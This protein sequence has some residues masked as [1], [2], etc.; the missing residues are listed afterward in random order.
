LDL[1]PELTAN[2]L[3]FAIVAALAALALPFL[4]RRGERWLPLQRLRRGA[5][6]GGEVFFLFVIYLYVPVLLRDVLEETRFFHVVFDAE[7]SRFR[8]FNL[9][10]PLALALMLALHVS[11]LHAVSGTRPRHLG[12]SLARWRPRVAAGI[13]GFLAAMP[14]VWM[15]WTA[16]IVVFGREAHQLETLARER[17][18]PVEWALLLV[19]A[20][21]L[22]PIGE[23]WLF[24]GLLQGWLRRASPAGHIGVALA[25]V[26]LG[27]LPT[28][29]A[30][31]REGEAA[32]EIPWHGLAFAA[33]L[34][35]IYLAGALRNWRPVLQGGLAHFV[36]PSRGAPSTAP[37]DGKSEN[38]APAP[39]PARPALQG[40]R[41]EQFK[42]ANA[43]WAIIGSAMLFAVGHFETW[44]APIALFPLG[45]VLGW[46]AYRT[47]S[48]IPSIVLHALF[49]VVAALVLVH[50]VYTGAIGNNETTPLRA[51]P[52][53][54]TVSSVPGF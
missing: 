28:L 17:L 45:I 47:Q 29:A 14:V 19:Q 20:A 52:A 15:I 49:N 46:L 24:R 11:I 3:S 23:E 5:W 16:A 50:A 38:A 13:V 21:V 30:L 9:I 18:A 2:A 27:A 39:N 36:E 41:W 25:A 8:Q 4:H 37:S 40:P 26:S 42:H 10:A 22:A 34:A 51:E 12:V 53:A 31:T 32:A 43:R 44:P 35:A 48:L 1:L 54:A 6:S 33:V 7:V